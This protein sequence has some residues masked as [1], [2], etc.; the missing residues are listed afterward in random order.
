MLRC[1]G[2]L[3]FKDLAVVALGSGL[4]SFVVAIILAY[5][6]FGFWSL[7]VQHIIATLF[8]SIGVYA[9]SKHLPRF[10]FSFRIFKE[11]FGFGINLMVS[12]R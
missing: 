8:S 6:H 1:S 7:I 12:V 2:S 5:N 10:D 3:R 9:Y 11:Q 4:I